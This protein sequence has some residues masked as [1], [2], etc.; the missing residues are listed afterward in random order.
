[1]QNMEDAHC[2]NACPRTYVENPMRVLQRCD[3]EFI[4][5]GK[6]EHMVA[7]TR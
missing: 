3:E 2:P 4:V 7:V 6:I 1:M 5:E